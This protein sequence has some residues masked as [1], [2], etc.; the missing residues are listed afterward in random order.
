MEYKFCGI[1][2][3]DNNSTGP[4]G[5]ISI[6]LVGSNSTCEVVQYYLKVDCRKLKEASNVKPIQK[7][8]ANKPIW[9]INGIIMKYFKISPKRENKIRQQMSK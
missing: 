1:N 2:F 5:N 9:K 7:I 6:L 3:L 8:M 4:S